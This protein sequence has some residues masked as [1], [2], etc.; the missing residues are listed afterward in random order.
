VRK[1]LARRNPIVRAA[2]REIMLYYG[3]II[4]TIIMH[5]S[6]NATKKDRSAAVFEPDVKSG[7]KL[8]DTWS[9]LGG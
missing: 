6:F 5:V 2:S 1:Y 7:L 9:R 4:Y 3:V 8:V